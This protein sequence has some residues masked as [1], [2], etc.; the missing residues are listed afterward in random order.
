MEQWT[1]SKLGKECIK[2]LQCHPAYLTYP[3]HITRNAGVDK[4]Q[5]GFKIA[6][7]NTDIYKWY[8]FNGRKWRG[9]KEQVKEENEKAGLKQHL[10]N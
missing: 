3:E 10:K 6:G 4:W 7:R 1:R 2:A 8:H 5:A 9:T